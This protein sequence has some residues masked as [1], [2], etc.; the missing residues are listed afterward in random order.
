M[1]LLNHKIHRLSEQKHW[2]ILIHGAGGSMRSWYKQ[3]DYFKD[4]FN[5]L[6]LDLRD[7][8][9]SQF[10]EELSQFELRDL[11]KDVI[12]LMDHLQIGKAHFMGVSMGS[13]IIQH[14]EMHAP[15]RMRSVI[16]AGGVFGLSLKIRFLVNSANLLARILPFRYLY[17]L[18]AWIIL[19]KKNHAPSR[20]LFIREAQRIPE[21]AFLR[22]LPI[23]SKLNKD[24]ESL[25]H[26]GV[27]V[28]YLIVMGDQDHVFLTPA[29][30]FAQKYLNVSIEVINNCGHLSNLEKPLDFNKFSLEFLNEQSASTI[31]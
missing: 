17:E 26:R 4:H 12:T 29:I 7:H 10:N 2:M 21:K 15:E 23:I 3:I 8:G 28:P 1:E 9:D 30:R 25:Y 5:L 13:M 24:I 19:P 31:Q 11:S 20:K 27:K 16:L 6:L 14:I 18:F 22:W